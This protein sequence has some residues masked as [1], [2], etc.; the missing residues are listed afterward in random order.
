MNQIVMLSS[1]PAVDVR[2]H[3][4]AAAIPQINVHDLIN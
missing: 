1:F 3:W 2:F 4:E